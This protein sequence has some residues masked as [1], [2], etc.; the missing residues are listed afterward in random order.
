LERIPSES[1]RTHQGHVYRYELASSFL[2]PNETVLDVACGIGYGAKPINENVVVRYIGVDK[3]LPDPEFIG[4]GKWYAGVDLNEWSP[5]FTF[6]VAI[7]IETLEHLANPKNLVA[8]LTKAKRLIFVSVPTRPTMH[9]NP[10]HLH[11]FTVDEIVQLFDGHELIHIED[12]PEELSHI[13]VFAR[14]GATGLSSQ[15]P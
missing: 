13:F 8:H 15:Q 11:D 9:M 2:F 14:K 6:D 4:L 3:V 12:Q 10:F 1:W 7:C 5:D